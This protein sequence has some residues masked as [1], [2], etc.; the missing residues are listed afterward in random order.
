MSAAVLQ[1]APS[2]SNHNGETGNST[3]V[4]LGQRGHSL[5]DSG[6]GSWPYILAFEFAGENLVEYGSDN[7]TVEYGN[8]DDYTSISIDNNSPSDETHIHLTIT[9]PALNIDP[10]TADKWRFNL[11]EPA[12]SSSNLSFASNETDTN[13][14]A[15]VDG[16]GLSLSEQGDMG[17]GDN[18]LLTNSTASA[19]A[20]VDGLRDI[21]MTET[22]SN[23]AVFESWATNGTSQLVTVDEA[24]GDKKSSLLL[25]WR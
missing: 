17:C 8:T 3:T 12:G 7:I 23:T 6:Y 10:T 11:A 4:D 21:V 5:N 16:G 19:N 1:N 9:D 14:V 22:D 15:L 20:I 2:L 18:C 13:G 24:G 25:W